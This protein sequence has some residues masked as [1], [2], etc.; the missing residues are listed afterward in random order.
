M[1]S[2]SIGPGDVLKSIG[3]WRLKTLKLCDLVIG[4]LLARVVPRKTVSQEVPRGIKRLLVIRPGGIGDAIFLLPFLRLIKTENPGITVDVLC[5]KRNAQIFESQRESCDDVLCYDRL[6]SFRE[7][8]QR[9]YDA[10]VDTEQWHYLSALVCYF[11]ACGYSIGFASR[12]LRKKLFSMA[13]DYQLDAHEIENFQ[14]LFLPV[15]PGVGRIADVAHSF[16]LGEAAREWARRQIPDSSITLF[17]G[18][19]IPLRRLSRQQTFEMIHYVLAKK[20]S[21]VLLGGGDVAQEGGAIVREIKD[22]R[23]MNF[24]GKISL[25]QTA[26]LIRHSR[27]FIGPDSGIMHLACAV[28]TPVIALFGSGNLQKWGPKG[29]R[30]RVVTLNLEC[31]PCTRFGYTI[32]TC[33]RTYKCM[34]DIKS[35]SVDSLI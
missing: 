14:N 15:F 19:S 11:M 30:D 6:S 7:V 28:G 31:S 32:P 27:F 2:V 23:V 5:E 35:G 13:V 20:F 21:V 17:L 9:Q 10:V 33:R 25:L 24:V 22:P 3:G 16:I 18:A 8:W 26:A 1:K 4:S 29:G 12:P 34:R